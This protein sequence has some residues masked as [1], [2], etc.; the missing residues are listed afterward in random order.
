MSRTSSALL[1]SALTLT[2]LVVPAAGAQAE[3]PHLQVHYSDSFD[4]VLP[5]PDDPEGWFCGGLT[6]V[7]LHTDV[8]GY[9]SVVEQGSDGF[10]Y[11]A[12][13]FRSTLGYTNPD[14]GLTYTVVRVRQVRDLRIV[15]NGD[16]TQTLTGLSSGSLWAYG[17]DGELLDV[18]HGRSFD[19]FGVDT[20]GTQDP[21]DDELTFIGSE[22][23][24]LR[25]TTDFCDDFLAATAG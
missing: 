11:F 18:Q 10:S 21:F 12:D 3:P 6:G 19:T 15:D 16:S 14:T 4:S 2:A 25:T 24:G 7:P 17:P 8:D 9:F 23:V 22:A 20:M 13:R 5:D 1:A